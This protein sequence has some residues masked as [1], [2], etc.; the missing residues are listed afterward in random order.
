MENRFKEIFHLLQKK[1]KGKKKFIHFHEGTKFRVGSLRRV[2]RRNA[3]L[4]FIEEAWS[5]RGKNKRAGRE[6]KK[7]RTAHCNTATIP[8]WRA[9]GS[10]CPRI[11]PSGVGGSYRWYEQLERPGSRLASVHQTVTRAREWWTLLKS[12]TVHGYPRNVGALEIP[13]WKAKPRVS[14]FVA[15]TVAA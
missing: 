10:S 11:F 2:S 1:K 14:R 6:G 12:G 5:E 4:F 8:W 9:R 13:G 7:E 15:L 3:S